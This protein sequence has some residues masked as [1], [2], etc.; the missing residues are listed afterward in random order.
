MKIGFER[1]GG[2][3]G[4]VTSKEIDTTTLPNSE[5]NQLRQLVETAD[6]FRLPAKITARTPQPDRFEYQL[7]VED[8]GKKHTVT[9]GEQA[10][11]GK[12]KPLL[13]WLDGVKNN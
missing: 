7:T 12:L 1:S 2:F 13:D 11:P 8:N 6:F 10:V 5:S 4:M 3:A 9:V